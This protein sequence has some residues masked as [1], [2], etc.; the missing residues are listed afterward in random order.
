MWLTKDSTLSRYGRFLSS[1]RVMA[2]S[3]TLAVAVALRT[4]RGASRV[5]R[6]S[7]S[8]PAASGKSSFSVQPCRH[9]SERARRVYSYPKDESGDIVIDEKSVTAAKELEEE[10][11]EVPGQEVGGEG[12]SEDLEQ[13]MSRVLE[14]QLASKS[15]ESE[16]HR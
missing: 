9:A 1:V 4:L 8:Y 2:S 13:K 3:G 7:T 16:Q 5:L 14:Q 11:V 12:S 10:T 6:I 15:V